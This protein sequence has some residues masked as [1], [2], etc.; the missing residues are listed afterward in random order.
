[1]KEKK[2]M[3]DNKFS[4]NREV[5]AETSLPNSAKGFGADY[6][7]YYMVF[8]MWNNVP[9]TL[10]TVETDYPEVTRWPFGFA[11][12]EDAS[13]DKKILVDCGMDE[14]AIEKFMDSKKVESRKIEKLGDTVKMLERLNLKPEEV[15]DVIL[16]HLHW[17]HASGIHLFPKAI[18]YL[19]KKELQWA[20][21]TPE[22]VFFAKYYK[23]NIVNNLV[24]YAF[25]G[26]VRFL[27]GDEQLF[28]G[29]KAWSTPGHTPGS[30]AVT[31]ESKTGLVTL[32]GDVSHSYG[33]FIKELPDVFHTDM[34]QMLQS[35][36][37]IKSIPG[38]DKN[39]LVLYHAIES[40][41]FSQ[42]A[43]SVYRIV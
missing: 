12:I 27:D 14:L 40:T 33:N 2:S 37:K 23:K 43:E 3:G 24:D 39:K 31:V 18:F 10:Q 7:V 29:I 1:M 22:F 17:D 25:D 28:D 5:S 9:T 20:V 41:K 30:Q 11:Y 4:C 8:S 13:L 35:Y 34:V 32:A 21:V 6:K 36:R 19:Q 16:T 42:A 26:R 38:F 15:T